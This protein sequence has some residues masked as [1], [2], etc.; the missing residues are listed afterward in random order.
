M[1]DLHQQHPRPHQQQRSLPVDAPD[2]TVR[3]EVIAVLVVLVGQG[4]RRQVDASV[5]PFTLYTQDG[6]VFSTSMKNV[7]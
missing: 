2:G 1:G 3:R 6:L 7:S 4:C 5:W